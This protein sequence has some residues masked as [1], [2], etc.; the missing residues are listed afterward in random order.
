MVQIDLWQYGMFII[1][2]FATLTL[3]HYAVYFYVGHNTTDREF[4]KEKSEHKYCTDNNDS[5]LFHSHRDLEI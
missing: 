3:L 1:A 4:R 5:T 2:R